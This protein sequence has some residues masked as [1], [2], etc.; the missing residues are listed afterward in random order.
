[1][2][3]FVFKVRKASYT[4]NMYIHLYSF[5]WLPRPLDQRGE[6][7]WPS[8]FKLSCHYTCKGLSWSWSHGSWIYNY[9]CNQCLSPLMLWVQI[10]LRW[11]VLDTTL[12]DICQWL[13]TG[14]WFSPVPSTNK[15]D[16][17]DITE[18]LLIV[19]LNTITLTLFIKHASLKN[20]LFVWYWFNYNNPWLNFFP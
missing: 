3:C 9:L 6:S 12:C 2:L 11:G 10:P 7:W 15:I 1:M 20:L 19:A 18:I 8:L 13:V 17:H 14:L 5:P 4:N 16:R